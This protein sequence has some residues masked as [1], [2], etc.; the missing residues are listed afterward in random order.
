M[1][2]GATR[3]PSWRMSTQK[4]NAAAEDA[5]LRSYVRTLSHGRLPGKL[6]IISVL[7]ASTPASAGAVH[8]HL[9]KAGLGADRFVASALIRFYSSAGRLASARKAFSGVCE[10]DVTLHTAMLGA[11]VENGD[12]VGARVM[13]D[14][15]LERDVVAWNGMLSGYVHCGLPEDALELFQEMQVSDSTPNE[16]TLVSVLSACSQLACLALGEW[17]H[18]YIGRVSDITVTPILINSMVNMY[19]KCGRLDA[20]FGLFLEQGPRNL[21][22]WNTMLSCFA[23]H[24]CGTA[25]LSLF[26]HM[27]K[28][29]VMP[30]RISFLAVL[31]ACAHASMVDHAL[32]CFDCMQRV[33]D[34]VPL[35]E[36]YGCLVDVLSRGGH[37]QE[38]HALI[39][40]MPFEPD[41]YAWGALLAGCCHYHN[42]EIGLEAANCLVELEPWEEGRYIA[43]LHIYAMSGK[44]EDFVKLRPEMV[45]LSILKL[46][47]SSLIE[48]DGVVH[49]F[50]AG[51]R[52]HCQ[53]K[54]IYMMVEDIGSNLGWN[55]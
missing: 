25:T 51:D 24:G 19:A 23:T 46:S 9:V 49:K 32:R 28:T 54:D 2:V 50:V 11:L 13:F 17:V 35:P 5:A 52:S 39:K 43:L 26:S 45:N 18:A 40:S 1:A 36:H 10:E 47:G 31:M 42:F 53:S 48:V 12:A 29:A 27:I 33:Y 20:A 55:V 16:V 3:A 7:K 4:K 34:F 41:G 30:D 21:E 6:A 14:D 8:A 15:M 37:L 38:A 44:R 22:S